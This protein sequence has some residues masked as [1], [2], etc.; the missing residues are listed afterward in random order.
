LDEKPENSDVKQESS[1]A[2]EGEDSLRLG[3][4]IVLSGFKECDY[5]ELIVVKKIVGNYARKFSDASTTFESLSLVMKSVHATQ[6][7]G[8][9]EIHSKIVDN[10]AVFASEVTDRNLF[11]AID[12]CLKKVSTEMGKK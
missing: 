3:G 1:L 10:G 2:A 7:S 5:S 12:S 11:F 9:F 8:K 6:I 4:N